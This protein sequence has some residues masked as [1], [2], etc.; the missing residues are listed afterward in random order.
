MIIVILIKF[1][2]AGFTIQIFSNLMEYL[3]QT[4]FSWLFRIQTVYSQLV[5]LSTVS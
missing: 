4:L 1:T 5:Y 2:F 3:K